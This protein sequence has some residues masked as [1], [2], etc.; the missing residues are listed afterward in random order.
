MRC[1]ISLQ[2]ILFTVLC[3]LYS[4]TISAQT[5]LKGQVIGSDGQAIPGASIKLKATNTGTNTDQNGNFN[6]SYTGQA[7]LVVSSIGY[8]SQEVSINGQTSLR[9]TLV[10]ASRS[11]NEVVVTA[12]GV[13]REKRLLTYSTQEV[14]ADDIARAKEPSL[15]NSLT[16][17]VAGVQITNSSGVAGSASR[18][19]IRGDIS[20]NSSN[21]LYVLDGVP[22]DNS[23]TSVG[24]DPAGS[25]VSR[26]IDIDPNNVESVNVL[27]G[28]AATALYGSR[29]AGGAVIIT[30]KTGGLNKR[31]SINFMSDYSFEN[32]INPKRQTIYAQGNNGLFANGED[33]KTSTSYGPR[34]DTLRINGAPAPSYDPYD[35]FRT[36]KTYNNSLNISGGGET[37]TYYLSYSLFNQEGINPGN[38]FKRHSFLAKYSA[39]VYKNLTTS[40]QLGYSNSTQHRLPEGNSQGPI[41]LVLYQP[42]SWNPYPIYDVNGAMRLFRF[43]RNAPLW[44]LDN[45]NNKDLVNRFLPVTTIN[46]TPTKWLTITERVGADVSVE[47]IKF[48]EN[49]SPA[50]GK[51]GL[52]RDQNIN[53]RQLNH[54]LIVSARKQFGKLDADLL[55]GNNFNSIYSQNTSINANGLQIK[56]FYNVSAGSTV[57][58]SEANYLERKVGFYAQGNLEYDKFLVLSLTGRYDGSSKLYKE[59]Q[60]YPYGSAAL[61]FIFT[62]FMPEASKVLNFGKLRF[63]YATVG[64]DL[65][66]PYA[67]TTPYY[68]P[69]RGTAIGYTD[70]PFQGQAG[71]MQGGT[72]SNP[73]LMNETLK[74]FETGL[75][76]KF[77]DNRLSL[78]GSYFNRKQT[79]GIIPSVEIS[80]ASGFSGTTVNSASMRNKGIELFLTGT[81]VKTKDFNWDISLNFS[82]IRNE[83]L[84]INDEKGITS[85]G[86]F[87]VGYPAG[88]FYGPK[89]ARDANGELLIND[90]G[91]PYSDGLGVV[92]DPNP[93][94]LGG[95][96]NTL[97]YRQFG[98][99]FFF[100]VKKGGD[101]QN[102]F[103]GLA[104]FYGTSK[105]TENR[106][107]VVVPGVNAATGL[108]NTKEISAQQYYQGISG[109]YEETIEDGTYIKLRNVSL[110]YNLSP[111]LFKKSPFKSA[112]LTVTGR[113][114][115]IHAPHFNGPDPEVSTYG[116]SNGDRAIYSFT[117][118]TARSIGFSLKLG[119]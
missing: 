119:F 90:I 2:T 79:D 105:Q 54:D 113:N 118:P 15:L 92:G 101:I 23:E 63:S 78:E 48:W 44:T 61:G 42:V 108:P 114:L 58:S 46:Y 39:K 104:L 106:A 8:E 98:L 100:D 43:S 19:V 22:I 7:T 49:P 86:R 62:R 99:S 33:Q 71:F 34:M 87:M 47:Q 102:D 30:T 32:S 20:T 55:L 6:I 12:I 38:D 57:T 1:R 80:A 14:K 81:P 45:M 73:Y 13:K 112:S 65:I 4:M 84:Q 111:S 17:K 52:I 83:V 103:E 76:L 24:G 37:A 5:L 27:K 31:P 11:L 94:W 64:N 53:Y 9:I 51:V 70:F 109:I 10:E 110:S 29:G 97:R 89:Y 28:A 74:E 68:S 85:V 72:L 77:F 88:V 25:G 35:F 116:T 26:I 50:I 95:L 36:G 60:F 41:A 3:L 91:L 69:G 16:G 117:T 40:F 115:W 107:P 67:L 56:G 93:D 82:R 59:E 96:N 18:V 66:G 21:P 75:E